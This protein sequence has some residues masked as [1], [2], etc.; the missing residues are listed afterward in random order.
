MAQQSSRYRWFAVLILFFFM[1]LHQTDKLMI[2][3]L[4]VAISATAALLQTIY[5]AAREL[6]GD[7]LQNRISL[8]ILRKAAAPDV[9]PAVALAGGKHGVQHLPRDMFAVEPRVDQDD[10]VTV[11][12][13][14]DDRLQLG[15]GTP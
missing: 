6:L 15:I 11:D 5:G 7:T 1:L 4:Q 3:S 2:G 13:G 10:F 8:R 12:A 14:G 9:E